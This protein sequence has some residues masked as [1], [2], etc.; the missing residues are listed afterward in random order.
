MAVDLAAIRADDLSAETPANQRLLDW[1]EK[2]D[3]DC[4][5][6]LEAFR[7]Y[8]ERHPMNALFLEDRHHWSPVGHR[9]AALEVQRALLEREWIRP[10]DD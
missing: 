5:G 2:A 3:L 1:C 7:A 4:I 8:A 6:T 10:A 9:L